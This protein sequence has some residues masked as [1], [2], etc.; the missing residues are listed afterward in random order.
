MGEIVD[1]LI[2]NV[3]AGLAG[4]LDVFDFPLC[5]LCDQPINYGSSDVVIIRLHDVICLGHGSCAAPPEQES[6]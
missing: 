3:V 5:P 4:E 6:V 2:V 1:K